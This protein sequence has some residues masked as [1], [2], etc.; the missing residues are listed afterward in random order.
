MLEL[1]ADVAE[2]GLQIE[3]IEHLALR[4]LDII[5]V[6]FVVRA[7]FGVLGAEFVPLLDHD[8]VRRRFVVE[9]LWS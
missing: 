9:A 1:D 3:T 6:S 7:V 2:E 5:A 8:A 4:Q